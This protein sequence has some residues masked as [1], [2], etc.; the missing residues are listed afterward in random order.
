[1]QLTLFNINQNLSMYLPKCHQKVFSRDYPKK[2]QNATKKVF[3]CHYPKRE[4]SIFAAYFV[5][6]LRH[7]S[8]HQSTL[9]AI[10]CFCVPFFTPKLGRKHK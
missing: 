10:L 2:D 6:K 7:E 4:Q 5:P 8:Q 9:E 3:S 1:M